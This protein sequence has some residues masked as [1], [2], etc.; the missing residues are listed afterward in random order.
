MKS[1]GDRV[2]EAAESGDVR[3]VEAYL[4]RGGNIEARDSRI[5]AVSIHTRIYSVGIPMAMFC[6]NATRRV[7]KR[8]GVI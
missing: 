1:E 3:A 6:F 8:C 4:E 2:T 5:G 7:Y